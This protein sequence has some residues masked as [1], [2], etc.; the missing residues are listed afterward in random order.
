VNYIEVTYGKEVLRFTVTLHGTVSQQLNS[1]D[2]FKYVNSYLASLS[3]GQNYELFSCYKKSQEIFHEYFVLKE[4]SD[5]IKVVAT[6]IYEIINPIKL[7]DW[8]IIHSGIPIHK[9]TQDKFEEDADKNIT[10]D[11]TYIKQDLYDLYTLTLIAKILFPLMGY[12]ISINRKQ[13]GNIMKEM[14]V[15]KFIGPTGF[16]SHPAYIK[17]AEY[18]EAI[19]KTSKE[20]EDKAMI[21]RGLGSD[22]VS[23][24]LLSMVVVNK[25]PYCDLDN[26]DNNIVK[27]I[28]KTIV[29]RITNSSRPSKGAIKDKHT[30][31]GD[32][33]GDNKISV[34][35]RYKS[36]SSFS[37]GNIVEFEY[38]LHNP[39]DVA[40]RIWVDY[41]HDSLVNSIFRASSLLDKNISTFQMDMV[42]WITKPVVSPHALQYFHKNTIVQL[43][44][45]VHEFLYT[46]GH[47]HLALWIMSE[48][49]EGGEDGDIYITN[50]DTKVRINPELQEEIF[51]LYPY[52][53]EYIALKDDPKRHPVMKTID[54]YV[55]EMKT[56]GW[57]MVADTKRIIETL[58]TPS[59]LYNIPADIKN[60]LAKL[61][62]DV[63]GRKF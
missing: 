11:K 22:N 33:D 39:F 4:T 50:V 3:D 29:Q 46:H 59:N 18:I 12:Y 51:A 62:C 7:R 61:I 45:I 15:M 36:K 13:I 56:K 19:I 38:T 48:C 25:L 40:N 30:E 1:G 26:V 24:W 53:K 28:Y 57:V 49:L 43:I 55:N 6:K 41:D 54:N 52:Q 17:L 34:L 27:I 35:E 20:V 63:G 21:M 2:V 5:E 10:R 32:Q 8:V 31:D 16:S 23:H 44:G 60:K 37:L 42:G 58:N 14:Y 9:D 47:P